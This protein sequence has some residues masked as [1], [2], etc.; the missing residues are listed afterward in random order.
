[1]IVGTVADIN[2]ALTDL[3][4]PCDGI[5]VRRAASAGSSTKAD[6]QI[7]QS[8]QF[9]KNLTFIQSCQ[10]WNK[11]LTI[12]GESFVLWVYRVVQCTADR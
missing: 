7:C 6:E 2:P 9:P 10:E 3:R 4:G 12:C 5:S 11:A 8:R 1:M